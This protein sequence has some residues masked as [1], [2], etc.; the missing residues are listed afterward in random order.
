MKKTVVVISLLSI[1]S[2]ACSKNKPHD[3]SEHQ[4][5]APAVKKAHKAANSDDCFKLEPNK[6]FTL[7]NNEETQIQIVPNLQQSECNSNR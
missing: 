6:Q 4:A 1:F 7:N 5:E 3:S 2:V